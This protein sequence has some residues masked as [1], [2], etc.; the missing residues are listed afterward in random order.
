M[1]S[2]CFLMLVLQ[3]VAAGNDKSF[4]D[5][6]DRFI[7]RADFLGTQEKDDVLFG[8]H[9]DD[10]TVNDM[11]DANLLQDQLD[12]YTEVQE[13]HNSTKTSGEKGGNGSKGGEGE[14]H[15]HHKLTVKEMLSFMESI[16]KKTKALCWM[17]SQVKELTQG[18]ESMVKSKM[19]MPMPR[20]TLVKLA[21]IRLTDVY[22]STI[23][24]KGMLKKM[25][26]TG[27]H[28]DDDDKRKA[29]LFRKDHQHGKP[30]I[31][32]QVKEFYGMMK[33]AYETMKHRSGDMEPTEQER[34][35]LKKM[36]DTI[37]Y[38]GPMLYKQ[39]QQMKKKLERMERRLTRRPLPPAPTSSPPSPPPKPTLPLSSLLNLTNMKIVKLYWTVGKMKSV[40]NERYQ[41][42]KNSSLPPSSL[43]K[44]GLMQVTDVFWNLKKLEAILFAGSKENKTQSAPTIKTKTSYPPDFQALQDTLSELHH[45]IKMCSAKPGDMTHESPMKFFFKQMILDSLKKLRVL[46]KQLK[47]MKNEMEA[48]VKLK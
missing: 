14:H 33:D 22:W 8:D 23:K 45:T 39:L 46:Y 12:F 5:E 2:L 25:N 32:E 43:V 40:F 31:F 34:M 24:L 42:N 44:I 1:K 19:T 11:D 17:M 13:D 37:L 4:E 30:S 28:D 20:S 48:I 10:K 15:H 29:R 38:D 21:T 3:L 18:T 9:Q 16:I 6:V 26:I 41:S 36:F 35:F 7:D 47:T 27:N